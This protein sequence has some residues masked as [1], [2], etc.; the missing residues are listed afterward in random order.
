MIKKNFFDDVK[1]EVE[2]QIAGIRDVL[3]ESLKHELTER[4][5]IKDIQKKLKEKL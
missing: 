2:G 3:G 5:G 4:K 1:G